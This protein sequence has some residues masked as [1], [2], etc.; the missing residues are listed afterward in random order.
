[1]DDI[2]FTGHVKV[3]YLGLFGNACRF[4]YVSWLSSPWWVL[5][6]EFVQGLTHALV[7]A[8]ACSYLTQGIETKNRST[9]QGIL[10]LIHHGLG[11]GSGAIIGGALVQ[12][13]GRDIKNFF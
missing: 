2:V 6:F 4:L 11:R 12:Y 7:W 9:A 1:M 5:P 8:S 10:Q 13:F 3:L